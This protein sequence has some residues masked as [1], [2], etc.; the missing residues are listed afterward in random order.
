MGQPV[1]CSDVYLCMKCKSKWKLG[2]PYYV[3]E[4]TCDCCRKRTTVSA[5]N[6]GRLRPFKIAPARA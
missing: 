2:N 5:A 3:Y 4:G 1:D 6:V